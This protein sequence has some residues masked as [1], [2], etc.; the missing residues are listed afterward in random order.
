MFNASLPHVTKRLGELK[1]ELS[2]T[3]ERMRGPGILFY[4]RSSEELQNRFRQTFSFVENLLTQ[5]SD[6]K[7]SLDIPDMSEFY[8]KQQQLFFERKRLWASRWNQ[9]RVALPLGTSSIDLS[10]QQLLGLRFCS[11]DFRENGEIVRM[12]AI[13]GGKPVKHTFML[14][15]PLD[16]ADRK[17]CKA[18]L[19]HMANTFRDLEQ[20]STV[21]RFE[22]AVRLSKYKESAEVASALGCQNLELWGRVASSFRNA[23][24]DVLSNVSM[25]TF[26]LEGRPGAKTNTVHL[27]LTNEFAR[28]RKASESGILQTAI[29]AWIL[30]CASKYAMRNA[31]DDFWVDVLASLQRSPPL[32]S[33][34]SLS[35]E[36][37]E[38][39]G[40][41]G[42][43]TPV[44]DNRCEELPNGTRHC[45]DWEAN[46][47]GFWSV[48]VLAD[49][50]VE[51]LSAIVMQA[52]QQSST[53]V[54]TIVAQNPV[55]YSAVGFDSPGVVDNSDW[56]CDQTDATCAV[57]PQCGRM[58]VQ[59]LQYPFGGNNTYAHSW[60]R[61]AMTFM[62]SPKGSFDADGF[63]DVCHVPGSAY[64]WTYTTCLQEM[65][66]WL[67]HDAE[68]ADLCCP[69][70]DVRKAC[71]RD[72]NSDECGAVCSRPAAHDSPT[73]TVDPRGVSADELA[74][75]HPTQ[76][77]LLAEQAAREASALCDVCS[78]I[79]S[80][81]EQLPIWAVVSMT[82]ACKRDEKLC[83]DVCGFKSQAD[84]LDECSQW[85]DRCKQQGC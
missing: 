9:V 69:N 34:H 30:H 36:Y 51:L 49:E 43:V 83:M 77:D 64:C 71:Y 29:H 65:L 14:L 1:V 37:W 85:S 76:E 78:S 11:A 45:L 42:I 26:R 58:A 46:F 68:T 84:D 10:S 7:S 72:V 67:C 15:G 54:W 66:K 12:P 35:A 32:M 60:T 6:T 13:L 23:I 25:L 70:D 44:D 22:Y 19:E 41:Q 48:A 73:P 2:R 20:P 3:L 4:L 75:I 8:S 33:A 18:V 62:T 5:G 40:A 50:S 53:G 28:F 17:D 59:M 81:G 52:A 47:D 80:L 31:A 82:P 61:R 24:R 74:W 21:N 16:V 27:N 79:S 57:H 55:T 56:D 38:Q 63:H 39:L